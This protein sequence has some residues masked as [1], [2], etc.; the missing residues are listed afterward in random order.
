M[1][2]SGVVMSSRV[3]LQRS[4]V[5]ENSDLECLGV[6]D[7]GGSGT[8]RN[9]APGHVPCIHVRFTRSSSSSCSRRELTPVV[10]LC[11]HRSAGGKLERVATGR[12]LA[13]GYCAV[14]KL[15]HERS[16]VRAHLHVPACP[17]RHRVRKR[18]LDRVIIC[19]RGG[20]EVGREGRPRALE[21]AQQAFRAGGRGV[22]DR[23]G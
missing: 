11:T 22:G 5:S 18:A 17:F 21:S 4:G 16:V 3:T 8:C 2:Y 23:L 6:W 19:L 15:R 12:T 13:S 9:A 7:A 10:A 20:A 14:G 1:R